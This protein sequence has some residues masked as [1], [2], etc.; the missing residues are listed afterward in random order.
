VLR[1]ARPVR[2]L[3]LVPHFAFFRTLHLQRE[4]SKKQK[5]KQKKNR[6]GQIVL[7]AMALQVS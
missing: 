1:H 6:A 7:R 4:E 5:Q 2:G 3:P